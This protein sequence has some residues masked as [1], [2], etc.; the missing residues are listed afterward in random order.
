MLTR[1]FLGSKCQLKKRKQVC[2]M[3]LILLSCLS[4][5]SEACNRETQQQNKF[6]CSTCSSCSAAQTA[7]SNV[8]ILSSANY[9]Y[10]ESLTQ[11]VLLQYK[12]TSYITNKLSQTL[13]IKPLFILFQ[14]INS[15]FTLLQF[16]AL[17]TVCF[18]WS[19]LHFQCPEK[20]SLLN[21]FV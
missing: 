13:Q 3:K 20:W 2:A 5:A 7:E 9:R 16:R 6:I 10:I 15:F 21:H 4:E 14:T 17:C 1:S 8:G 18:K 19:F 12:R 11:K